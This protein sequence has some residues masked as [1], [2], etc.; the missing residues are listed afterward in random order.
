MNRWA[1][2][3]GVGWGNAVGRSK[4]YRIAIDLGIA[5]QGRPAVSLGGNGPAISDDGFAK[6]LDAESLEVAD[7]LKSWAAFPV[8]SIGVSR[9]F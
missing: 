8:L 6:R 2:Y 7:R 1:P 9:R 5:A 4:R 3:F